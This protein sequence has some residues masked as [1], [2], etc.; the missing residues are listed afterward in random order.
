MLAMLSQAAS[1][2]A[3][4]LKE[5]VWGEGQPAGGFAGSAV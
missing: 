2:K 3:E 4:Q 1:E 5:E